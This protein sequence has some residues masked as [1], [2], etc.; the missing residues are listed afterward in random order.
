[1]IDPFVF[2][3]IQSLIAAAVG[4]IL[5]AIIWYIV[6]LVKHRNDV[7][8]IGWASYFIMIAVGTYALHWP[9]V[10]LRL[11]PILVVLIWGFRLSSHIAARHAVSGEDKRYLA[12]RAAWG[13][14]WYFYVRS[15]L[16]VFFLQG[17]LAFVIAAPLIVLGTFGPLRPLW[18]GLGL[19]VWVTGFLIEKTADEDLAAHLKKA[20][21]PS[22]CQKG[23]WSYS[24]HP[25]YFGEAVQ[26][27]GV[28]IMAI[29]APFWLPAIIGPVTITFL[30]RFVSGV[31]MTEKGMERLPGFEEYKKR[32]NVFVLWVRK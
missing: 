31:P 9:R 22:I 15:F 29:G 11:M 27:W 21:I 8:D 5:L 17:I 1:M 32:T 13:N 6:S 18:V 25:N 4:V 20:T 30:L 7:A 24:R 19:L 16:Q 23:L 28:W 26:W 12:W 10:D 3:L 2:S 14:G